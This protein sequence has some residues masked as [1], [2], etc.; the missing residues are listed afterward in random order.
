MRRVSLLLWVL[1]CVFTLPT[2]AAGATGASAHPDHITLTWTGDPATTMTITWRT[3]T[4]VASGRVQYQAGGALAGAVQEMAASMTDLPTDLGTFRLF[5][6]KLTGLEANTLYAYRV[7]DGQRWSPQLT[8]ATADPFARTFKFLVFGDSQS[9]AGGPAPYSQWRKTVRNAFTAHPDAKF[10]V[11]VGDLVDVGQSGAH[12]NAWFAAAA[13]V[14]DSI[15]VMPALGNH[16]TYGGGTP[17]PSY[18]L[19]QFALPQN[20][21]ATLK[22]HAYAFDY[23]S[24]HGVV[25]DSQQGEQRRFGDILTPQKKWLETDLAASTATWKLAFFHKAPYSLKNGRSNTEIEKAFCPALERHGVDLVIN[26]HDHGYGRSHPMKGGARAAQGT[27]YLIAGRSGIKTYGDCQRQPWNAFFYNPLDQPNYL[28]VDVV[29]MRLTVRAVKQDGTL[30]DSF[31]LEKA[32][33]GQ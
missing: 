30:I 4:T 33:A 18:W 32:V 25:L 9:V 27:I 3:D 28:V 17:K 29:D 10:I 15:P 19:A 12:W 23:G 6:A 20:G 22:D 14:I 21:P 8:F 7:G 5:T 24:L 16:E 1:L 26:G 2:F 13:G 11:C 31:T